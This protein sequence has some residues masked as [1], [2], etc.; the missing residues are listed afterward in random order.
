MSTVLVSIAPCGHAIR[1]GRPPSSLERMDPGCLSDLL[2]G[3]VLKI[4]GLAEFKEKYAATMLCD[5]AEEA[6]SAS[7]NSALRLPT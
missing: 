1:A 2:D 4:I 5:C 6:L 3:A 7:L